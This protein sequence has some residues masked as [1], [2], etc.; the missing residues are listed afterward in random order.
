MKIGFDAK[1]AFFNHTGLGNYSRTLIQSLLTYFPENDYHF[2]TPKK[3]PVQ[4]FLNPYIFN[5]NVKIHQPEGFINQ[6][7]PAL[8]RSLRLGED[9]KRDEIDV[10]HGLSHELPNDIKKSKAKS[11]VTIH[12][13]IFERYP[14]YYGV[15]DQYIYRNKI[16]SACQNADT[17]IAI[18]EQTKRDLI[19]F[20]KINPS[21]I[22]VIYQSCDPIFYK[23]SDLKTKR[24]LQQKYNLPKDFLLYVGSIIPRKNLLGLVKAI[25][26]LPKT[27]ELPLVIVG[28]GKAYKKEVLAYI[29][30][31][32]LGNRIFFLK[33]ISFED[34]PTLYQLAKIMIYP[35]H[36]EGFGIP[37]IEALHSET[38]VITSQGSCFKE[39]GGAGALY[40]N[41][42]SIESIKSTII[43]LL[44]SENLQKELIQAGQ[45]QVQQFMPKLIAEKVYRV[46]E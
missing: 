3:P 26:N 36:F 24:K 18:S 15:I 13:L 43:Q 9:L 44:E 27:L 31:H 29:E 40:V 35:S 10:Y 42:E 45:K 22:K 33:D 38:P 39:A 41:S 20:Y 19:D 30:K 1:R 12:D 8:W 17:I 5:E 25:A 7:I 11:I 46:Y 6:N 23:K 14:E 34:L 21:K 28:Q 4:N 37:I 32:N 16:K 2:Y